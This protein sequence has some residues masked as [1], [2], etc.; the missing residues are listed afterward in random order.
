VGLIGWSRVR[1]GD[2]TT[3]QVLA[4]TLLGVPLAA[5]AFAFLR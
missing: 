1:L 4:G 2:H 3:G 5:A